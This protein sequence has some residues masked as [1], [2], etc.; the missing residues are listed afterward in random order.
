MEYERH[1]E[2]SVFE[3]QAELKNGNYHHGAYEPF[4]VW[5]PKQRRI[6]KAGVAIGW[7]TRRL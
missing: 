4:T 1:L 3:L 2:S 5:D 6:H 7:C